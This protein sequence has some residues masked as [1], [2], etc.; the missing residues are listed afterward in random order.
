M[1]YILDNCFKE[2]CKNKRISNISVKILHKAIKE[3]YNYASA[4]SEVKKCVRNSIWLNLP[5][6]PTSSQWNLSKKKALQ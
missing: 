5:E 6:F 1:K 2:N 4:I 3:Y